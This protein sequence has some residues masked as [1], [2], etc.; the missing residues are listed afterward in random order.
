MAA[1][2]SLDPVDGHEFLPRG[3]IEVSEAR[4]LLAASSGTCAYEADGSIANDTLKNPTVALGH[5]FTPQRPPAA[6]PVDVHDDMVVWGGSLTD[7]FGHFLSEAVTRL[8]PLVP[9]NGLE[10]LPVVFRAPKRAPF[11][12]EWLEGFGAEALFL[13][14]HGPVRF[15]RM[16]V[17]ERSWRFG[18]W[19]APEIRDTHL[20][21]RRGLTVPS[22]PSHDVLW[23]SRTG[24]QP[25]RVA[26]DECLLEWILGDHVTPVRLE[27]MSLGQQIGLLESSRAVAGV[28]GSAFHALLLTTDTPECLYLSPPSFTRSGYLAQHRL[29]D[30]NAT[31][32]EAVASAARIPSVRRKGLIFPGGHRIL[33]PRA[34]TALGAT[35]MPELREDPRIVAFADPG[36][37]RNQSG[38][39]SET[40]AAVLEV[41]REPLSATARNR[42]GEMFDER[43]LDGCAFEQF[44]IAAEL[45]A[46]D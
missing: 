32:V 20:H 35:L 7:H 17:P 1:R 28:I 45:A 6:D 24:L 42:L 19:I 10:G 46:V 14:A 13:P 4:E 43:N 39:R 16:A 22:T 27:A 9:G 30:G 26:H 41:L 5:G 25:E 38:T 44:G 12:G 29:L 40:D 2:E 37:R 23:L 8:W 21:A 11:V 31:F 3:A 34:L 18:A 33:I 36:P 15:K